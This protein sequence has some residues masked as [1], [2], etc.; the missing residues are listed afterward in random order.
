[1]PITITHVVAS[2]ITV[3]GVVVG[4][5][6]LVVRVR[7][8]RGTERQ[9]LRRVALAAVLA[10]L[11]ILVVLAGMAVGNAALL[12][13]AAGISFA[14][15]PLAIGAAVARYRLYDLDRIASRTLAGVVVAAATTTT[16]RCGLDRRQQVAR[17]E[18][19]NSMTGA[20]PQARDSPGQ[21]EG[22]SP[23]EAG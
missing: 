16:R 3:I 20:A 7:R 6:S 13:W 4:A 10:S 9:Q 12:I 11:A 19:T 15:L 1:L 22:G 18:V 14:I 2:G 8:A 17:G 21:G 23:S 5:L